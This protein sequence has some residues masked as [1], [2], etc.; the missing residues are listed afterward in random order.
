M[1]PL[2]KPQCPNCR[3]NDKVYFD[4]VENGTRWLKCN[5]CGHK[6]IS[7]EAKCQ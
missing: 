7:A 2:A 4:H 6:W 5:S 1:S 3:K